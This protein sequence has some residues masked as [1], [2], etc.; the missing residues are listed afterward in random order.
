MT[1]QRLQDTRDEVDRFVHRHQLD[2]SLLQLRLLGLLLLSVELGTLLVAAGF[3]GFDTPLARLTGLV[4]LSPTLPLLPLGFCLYLLG[5]G[6][7]RHRREQMWTPA[8]HRAL[9]PVAMLCLL[10]LPAVT[11]HEAF[12]LF[13][14]KQRR[15]ESQ[16]ELRAR[17]QQ[18]LERI[19]A[20][21]SAAEV[22]R[23]ARAQGLEIPDVADEPKAI[24]L[25]R[26][27]MAQERQRRESEAAASLVSPSPFQ[28][29][30][31]SPVRLL[32]T[33]VVQVITGAGLLLMRRQGRLHMRR[34]GLTPVLFFRTD[35]TGPVR[36]PRRRST[37]VD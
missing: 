19:Q 11:L 18:N 9:L 28:Q 32:T 12:S 34:L 22:A 2:Y 33:L 36:Q 35:A 31:L 26:Y 21:P 1:N 8:L 20:A 24:G 37:D 6:H 16:E 15:L 30:I 23:L 29:E 27:D 3:G 7:R 17:Q 10:A 14:Q 25:W 4:G 13:S 5:G